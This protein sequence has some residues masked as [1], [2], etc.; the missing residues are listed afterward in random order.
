VSIDRLDELRRLVIDDPR[1]R[2]RLLAAP[3]RDAFVADVVAV[4]HEQ[5][6]DLAAD[7]VRAGLQAEQ[8]RR[9]E[10]WV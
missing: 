2:D 3:D 4:A 6:I 1:L 7:E 10:Q 5:G 9:F 8:R